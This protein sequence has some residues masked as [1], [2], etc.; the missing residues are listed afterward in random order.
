M[1]LQAGQ[2]FRLFLK[3]LHT[4]SAMMWLGGAQAVLV[5]LYKDRQAANGDEL[6][7][8][9][10]AI[11][12]LDNWLIAPG[13][14]GS[15][16]SGGLLCFCTSWGFFRHRWVAVKWVITVVAT[17]FGIA[18]LGPWLQDLS[19]ISGLN[20]LAVFDSWAYSQTYR[21]GVA[22]GI[23]QTVVLLAL[24]FISILK[25]GFERLP[26][27][28]RRVRVLFRPLVAPVAGLHGQIFNRI[29]LDR[30]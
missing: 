4:F 19:E 20:R 8:F 3:Y 11:R 7:A 10:D 2:Q 6:F 16:I 25:P 22:F 14:A 12:S 27:V 29:R 9:N 15:L 5:L 21:L 24:V 26:V 23:A 17:V 30:D 13:V 28:D 1:R 18:F